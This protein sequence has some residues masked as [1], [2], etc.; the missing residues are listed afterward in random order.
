MEYDRETERFVLLCEPVD[1]RQCDLLLEML[2]KENIPAF[3]RDNGAG[4]YVRIM[5]GGSIFGSKIF[6]PISAQ[7][8]A[9]ELWAAVERAE[10]PEFSDMELTA[11]YEEY[12]R[13][14]P[15]NRKENGEEKNG[16]RLFGYFLLGFGV[17]IAAALL[18][19]AIR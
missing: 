1:D 3:S 8:R 13:A 7:T 11:A 4:G 18:I 19:L 16:Y 9:E 14:C 15:E 10:Q 5:T 6:V 2:K 17:L 12:M